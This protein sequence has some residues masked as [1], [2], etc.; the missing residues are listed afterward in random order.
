M[1][2]A[3]AGLLIAAGAAGTTYAL[4]SQPGGSGPPA[5]PSVSHYQS[6]LGWSIRFPRGMHVEHSAAAGISFAVS[7]AT[8]ANFSLRHGVRRHKKPTSLSISTLPPRAIHGGFPARGIAVRVL[9]LHT[10][11]PIPPSGARHPPLQLNTFQR[12]DGSWYSGTR[13][14][15]LQQKLALDGR[16][17][18]VQVWLGPNASAP[19]RSRLTRIVAAIS[20]RGTH[21]TS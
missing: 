8:V 17:Y 20:S 19:Q 7:E 12:A 3:L 13:P 2:I 4:R 6:S 15:P 10:L 18:Y 5:A 11:G 1:R 9:W 16:T 21:T 14:R